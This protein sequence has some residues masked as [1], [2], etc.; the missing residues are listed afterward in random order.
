MHTFLSTL[1][2]QSDGQGANSGQGLHTNT[3][4]SCRT[5]TCRCND[6]A[7][8]NQSGLCRQNGLHEPHLTP[9]CQGLYHSGGS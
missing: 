7:R 9:E 8:T 6:G 1:E 5:M 3:P 2:A 4:G